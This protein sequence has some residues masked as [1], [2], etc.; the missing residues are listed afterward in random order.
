M[1]ACGRAKHPT[2]NKIITSDP[3]SGSDTLL[4]DAL[5]FKK[6]HRTGLR[7]LRVKRNATIASKP[8][9]GAANKNVKP[10]FAKWIADS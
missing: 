2:N 10:H 9:F 5:G 4:S 6:N 7:T 3:R 8:S 1:K